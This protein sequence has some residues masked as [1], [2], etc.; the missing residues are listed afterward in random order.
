[1]NVNVDSLCERLDRL[2]T[3]RSDFESLWQRVADLVMPTKG[4]FTVKRM[5]GERNT[6]NIFDSTPTTSV[7]LLAAGLH[8][9]V[10]NPSVQ[11]FA[12]TLD[13]DPD[14]QIGN[15]WLKD[16]RDLMLKEINRPQ[17]GFAT[18]IHEVYQDLALFGTG[19]LF[20]KYNSKEK[21]L[22][23]QSIPLNQVFIEEDYV[24]NVG[25]VFRCF[26]LNYAQLEEMFGQEAL[27]YAV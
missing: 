7:N 2:K 8:G 17:A 18:N 26:E 22:Q 1:M 20:V 27:P 12:L 14:S 19:C 24:G 21:R 16:V 25:S 4:N 6:N 15:K 23:F 11:W 13:K 3:D 9:M 10:T 5:P